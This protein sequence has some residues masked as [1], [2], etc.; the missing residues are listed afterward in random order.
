[1]SQQLCQYISTLPQNNCPSCG[2][3]GVNISPS[4]NIEIMK[5]PYAQRPPINCI[6][7][8]NICSTNLCNICSTN[9]YK[10][11]HNIG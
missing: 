11:S 2:N 1:M 4:V 10:N 6:Y 3:I 8:C 9:H 5:L 7:L